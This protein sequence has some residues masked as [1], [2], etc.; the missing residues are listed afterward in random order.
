MLGAIFGPLRRAAAARSPEHAAL[1]QRLVAV[2]T[3]LWF[4]YPVVWAL[5]TEGS[6]VI[7]LSAEV[8]IFAVVDLLAKVGF[9]L[10]LILGLSRLP[11][12]YATSEPIGAGR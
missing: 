3:V 1:Y 11:A 10:L 7:G 4:V 9:G 12:S 5:G 8:G 2:L 6:E